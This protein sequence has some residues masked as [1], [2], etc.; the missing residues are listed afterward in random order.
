[1]EN[2]R[3]AQDHDLMIENKEKQQD[4]DTVLFYLQRNW[5]KLDIQVKFILCCLK[6][7]LRQYWQRL[8]RES[9][10]WRL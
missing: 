1:M 7:N 10:G 4:T 2:Y 6:I 5:A 9:K 8:R 3:K